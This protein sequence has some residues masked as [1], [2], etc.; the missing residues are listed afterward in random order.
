MTLRQAI[1]NFLVPLTIAEVENELEISIDN[2]DMVRA[3]LV[4]EFLFELYAELGE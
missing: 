3:E 2:G 4:R 1:R